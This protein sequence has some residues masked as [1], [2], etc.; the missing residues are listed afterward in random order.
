MTWYRN[1]KLAT[2]LI[3]AF[4]LV[5]LV[6]VLVGLR[7]LGNTR[8][9]AG[10]MKE[11]YDN[12]LISVSLVGKARSA[13]VMYARLVNN[14]YVAPDAEHRRTVGEGLA[15]A[16]ANLF[17][18]IKEERATRMAPE[19]VA[20]WAS[21]DKIWGPYE[22]ANKRFLALV[23]AN[24]HA[25]ASTFLFAEVRPKTLELDRTFK[26]IEEVNLQ[27]AA[28]TQKKSLEAVASIQ[29]QTLALIALGFAVAVGLGLAVSSILR[30][31]VGGELSEASDVARRVAAGDLS[32]DVNTAPGDTT[33]M[34]ASIKDMVG[35]LSEVVGKVQEA[36]NSMA[37]AAEQLS[38]TAQSI[39]QGASEQAASVEE[40]SA[41]MEQMS[42]SIAQTND[43]ARTTGGLATAT[44]KD[45]VEGGQ[46][47]RETVGAMREIA[48][49]IGI[50][51]DIAYQTNLLALNA[52]I[53]AGRAGEHGR[54][55]AVVAAEVR[56]L[57]E[58]SQ[59]AAEEISRLASGSVDLA[60][61][62]GHLLGT[63]VPSIQKTSDLVSEI[64]SASAEQN[65]GVGQINGAIA[66]ISQAVAQNA[67]A[68]EELASTAEEV[69]SN[70]LELQNVMAFFRLKGGSAEPARRKAAALPRVR[71]ARTF[72]EPGFARF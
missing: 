20:L 51:D 25:E 72:D 3:L 21:F 2:Q 41:S 30:K 55:F 45:T 61:R 36:S 26:A 69:T 5:A 7:G 18:R 44:A 70:A 58:R 47:V 56:K 42:A 57:A 50:I 48:Q 24:K 60:E 59:V 8:T 10:M 12:N 37:G 4:T 23:D 14:Y 63:I 11:M 1:L 31:Q 66:Q 6:A 49:K 71:D 64:A 33:S 28:A 16:Q 43:N 67:A 65:S 38:S 32:V 53:E 52:A 19:E 68:S 40:T 62:A 46:A 13:G 29:N 22:E 17:E 27:D 54:G 34:M 9:V 15:A 35:R 39:S